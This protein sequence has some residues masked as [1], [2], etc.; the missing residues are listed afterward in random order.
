MSIVD[1][2]L[3]NAEAT[4]LTHRRVRFY[5]RKNV[6]KRKKE[7]KKERR[8]T[9]KKNEKAAAPFEEREEREREREREERDDQQRASCYVAAS[10]SRK[11]QSMLLEGFKEEEAPRRF[12]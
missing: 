10:D 2:F 7:R 8:K 6:K 1:I 9:E 11:H 4:L 12:L 3:Q 5:S